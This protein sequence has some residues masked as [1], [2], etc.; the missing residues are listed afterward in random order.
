V[1]V[2]AAA[3]GCE[4]AVLAQQRHSSPQ[5]PHEQTD[6]QSILLD[7]KSS[8]RARAIKRITIDLVS[9]IMNKN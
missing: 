5:Q 1:A 9:I 6:G 8:G 3:G 4:G 7:G 2:V